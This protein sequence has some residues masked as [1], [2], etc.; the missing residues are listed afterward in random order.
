MHAKLVYQKRVDDVLSAAHRHKQITK[1]A[2]TV[3]DI[4]QHCRKLTEMSEIIPV[5]A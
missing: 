3:N 2:N 1:L 5:K 4:F